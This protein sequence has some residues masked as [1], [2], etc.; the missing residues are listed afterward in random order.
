MTVVLGLLAAAFYGVGDFAGG[1]ASR[2]RSALDVLLHSYPVGA[3]LMLALVPLFPG[4][5]DARVAVFGTAGGI[6]GLMG[7]LVMY[8]LMTRAPMNVISPITAVL[9][10]IVPVGV[11]VVT[12]DRPPLSAWFGIVL[13]LIAVVLVSRTSEQHPHGRLGTRIIALAFLAGVGF[14]LYFVFL[15]RAGHH[16]GL[17]P[18]VVS[19]IAS[20][21]LIVPLALRRGRPDLIRGSVAGNRR[22]RGR[23]R[24]PGQHVLPA[25][26]PP[27]PALARERPDVAL[28]GGHGD[29]GRRP[30]P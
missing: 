1:F 9:A 21:V 30:A 25:G 12:G 15:A 16:S 13:G 24:R 4:H 23:V 18:L 27:R 19:R 3:V 28:P 14:G 6:F 11:G 7:V 17:W 20:A 29:P 10:A 5:L 8:D 2:R 26:E 22:A